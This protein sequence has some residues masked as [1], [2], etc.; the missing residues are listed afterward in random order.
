MRSFVLIHEHEWLFLIS[1]GLHPF[2]GQICNHIGGVTNMLDHLVV[3]TIAIF[4]QSHGRV[5]VRTLSN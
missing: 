4:V 5:I 3:F 2:E 1:F